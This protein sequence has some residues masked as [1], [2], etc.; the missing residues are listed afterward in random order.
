LIFKPRSDV[1]TL[2]LVGFVGIFLSIPFLP[3]IDG[4]NR[5]YAS[6][7]PFFFVLLAAG[8][9]RFIRVDETPA[10]VKNELFFLRLISVSLLVLIV[11]LPPLTLRASSRPAF[12]APACSPEQRPFVIRVIQGSYI[13][14]VGDENTSCGLAPEICLD[15]FRK[16]NTE[17]GIDDF[18]Q[19]LDTIASSSPSGLR[20]IP[21]I[22]LLDGYFQYFVLADGQV[23]AVPSQGLFSG[24]AAR[25]QT[26]NQRIFLI[27]SLSVS[28]E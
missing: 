9:S 27:E 14:L 10:P 18:Y 21:T 13:D 2:V 25:V 8:S 20:I 7:M 3:P 26:E 12:N 22:N 11:L 28:D 16:H 5:F 6:S 4:G 15:D 23:P 17:I 19:G 24:C 1:S